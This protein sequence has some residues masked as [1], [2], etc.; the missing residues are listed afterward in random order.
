MFRTLM[1]GATVVAL[2]AAVTPA[3]SISVA[4][5]GVAAAKK[6]TATKAPSGPQ[7]AVLETVLGKIAIKLHDKDAPKTVANFKKLVREKF[8]DST[9]FHR[10]IPGF[11]IQGGDP[12]SKNDD[13]SD[14]G[15]G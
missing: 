14:D 9:Y 3:R 4:A 11:M 2:V 7:V 12:N 10:V 13:P 6:V 1:L 8:Y 15:V 5:T